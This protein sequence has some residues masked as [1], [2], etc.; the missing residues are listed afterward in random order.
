MIHYLLLF[1]SFFVV[2]SGQ[3]QD[4]RT[5]SLQA[6][7]EESLYFSERTL[8]LPFLITAPAD[9]RGQAAWALTVNNRVV[10]RGSRAIQTAANQT[11]LVINL[12]TPELSKPI[13]LS[14]ELSIALTENND[15]QI[16]KLV[17]T[18]YLVGPNLLDGRGEWVKRLNLAVF[19]PRQHTAPR[20][21]EMGFIYRSLANSEEIGSLEHG[22]LIVGENTSFRAY[23]NLAEYLFAAAARGIGVVCLAPVDGTWQLPDRTAGDGVSGAASIELNGKDVL[24]EFDKRLPGNVPIAKHFALCAKQDA[25]VLSVDEHVGWEWCDIRYDKRPGR[26]LLCG[27]GLISSWEGNP[28]PRLFLLRILENLNP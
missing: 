25:V 9:W 12:R 6:V 2:A 15:L 8:K 10:D 28:G 24:A 23:P 14:G 1:T 19:D 18:V 27:F 17:K 20:L 3:S 4:G 11:T 22:I 13:L 5:V 16:V 7:G 21:R 26:L